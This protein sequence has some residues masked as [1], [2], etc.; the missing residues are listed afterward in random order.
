M[1][2]R[3]MHDYSMTAMLVALLAFACCEL[4]HIRCHLGRHLATLAQQAQ[5]AASGGEYLHAEVEDAL[6]N[7]NCPICH[8]ALAMAAAAGQGPLFFRPGHAAAISPTNHIIIFRFEAK[9]F[10]RGPPRACC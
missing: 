8:G 6:E 3:R 7:D 4:V 9:I 1:K 10:T 2:L 5:A